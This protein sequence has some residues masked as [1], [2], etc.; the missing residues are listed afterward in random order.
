MFSSE[1]AKQL[2]DSHTTLGVQVK[3]LT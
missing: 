1:L 2:H 3:F